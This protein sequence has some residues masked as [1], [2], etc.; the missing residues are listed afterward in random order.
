M[1]YLKYGRDWKRNAD[2][3]ISEICA[4]AAEDR[5]RRILLVP[6]Q[7]SFDMEWAL[8]E[9]GGDS[10]SRYAEVLSFT[11]LATRVFSQ[12]G[13]AAV[14][15]LD[16]SGRLIALAGAMDQIR[17]KL[18]LYGNQITKPEFLEELLR[19]LD[20]FY[21]CGLHAD[22]V[23]AVR[24]QIDGRLA[25]KLEELCL[26]QESY[27][28][29]CSGS[30][31]DPSARLDRLREAIWE[32]DFG[33]H[34]RVVV[35]GFSDFTVQELKVLEA[36][37]LHVDQMT[38]YLT[39]DS[40]GYGQSVFSV[41]RKTARALEQLAKKHQIL[42]RTAPILASNQPTELG[43]LRE[44][45]F[46]PAGPAWEAETGKVT[47]YA[48]HSAAEECASALGWVQQL[49][50][51]GVRYRDLAI[52]YTDET[53][54]PPMIENLLSENEIPAYY[55]GTRELLRHPVVRG[56]LYALEAAACGMDAESVSEYLK[57]GYSQISADEADRLENYGYVWN[58]RGT[59]W[60]APFDRN[61]GG[62]QK[63]ENVD[64]ALV[65]KQLA[66]LNR[67][68]EL[69]I[70]PLGALRRSLQEAANT[71][72][73]I[74]ALERFLREIRLAEALE[75]KTGR[76]VEQGKAQQAQELS[77]LY[78]ILLSTME[79][80]YGVLGKTVRS[81]DEFFRLFRAA[82]TQNTVGT[83]PAALD[84]VRVGAL[85]SIRNLR[86][87][88][89]LILGA[90]D[91]LLPSLADSP[92]LL[93]DMERSVMAQAG[94][95]VAPDR[96]ERMDRELLTAFTAFTAPESSLYVSAEADSPSY[97]FTRLTKLFPMAQRG[98]FQPCPVTV[99]QAAAALASEAASDREAALTRLP[100]LRERTQDLLRR[101]A[102]EPERLSAEAVRALYGTSLSLTS[103]RIDKFASCRYAY[104]L[105]Y[106]VGAEE[107]KQAGVDASL[108]GV[109]VHYVLQYTVEAVQKE[110]GFHKVSLERTLELAEQFCNQFVTER[111]GDLDAWPARDA[112]LFRRNFREVS[113]VVTGLYEE[114][115]QSDFI[116]TSFELAFEHDTAIPI[117]GN[118]ASGSL[119]GVVD[120]VDLYT[121]QAGKT[122]L[123]VID[124]KTGKKDFDYTDLLEGVGLQM[125]IY[126]FALTREAER[127]YGR[128]LLPAG[129]L[130][131]PARYDVETTKS[132]LTEEAA[133]EEHRKTLR[134]K[135]LLLDDEE[136]LQAMEAGENPVYLPFKTSRKDG[137]RSGDLADAARLS[138]AER[139]VFR[140]VGRMTD[141]I[142]AGEIRANP[143]WRGPDQNACR[144]CEYREI[145]RVDSGELPVR[146]RK[147]IGAEEFWD[148]LEE[149]DESDGSN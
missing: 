18:K 43:F 77:Q 63:D 84:N 37:L 134:R 96:C 98:P 100:E 60:E 103:S 140:N 1:L 2:E 38:V 5:Y 83:V 32:S 59:R 57:S 85:S 144:W 94:L 10:I 110:G 72:E 31:Q 91:G 41:P 66:A 74:E 47:L 139:F 86:V 22:D 125:L 88:H 143:Y 117:S 87:K 54:F 11:R 101:A 89:L 33:M 115:H 130:Y 148:T 97:L 146:R 62:L 14:T 27:E 61:P 70:A 132:R 109:F 42:F 56:V 9:R 75:E 80:I 67:S 92:G 111:L 99:E 133:E 40:L 78:E 147:A 28:S 49:I 44:N 145:C 23:R 30:V 16:K 35:V 36:L 137:T 135:G 73:Q 45:L 82:L 104:F 71:A 127:F 95:S 25:E 113:E 81:P 52:A 12:V 51:S 121:T 39:C 4:G 21:S 108:Y 142:A 76:L 15:S 93:S 118:L 3:A 55:S 65:E 112:Y 136:I 20:E 26:I 126:L 116:P 122:Y 6:E 17:P 106:G 107:R 114:M 58:L 90:S 131:F 48:A 149:E 29:V 123:R 105:R 138:R 19:L 128:K 50:Q 13:G 120:R 34:M 102:Y 53:V 46:S 7:S 64:H 79:Q 124:Y 129:V 69:A 119:R 141:E 24:E 8:C 68:R